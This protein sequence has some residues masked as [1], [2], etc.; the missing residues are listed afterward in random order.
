M[1]STA[2]SVQ[3]GIAAMRSGP[4]TM[5]L[6]RIYTMPGQHLRDVDMSACFRRCSISVNRQQKKLGAVQPE[7]EPLAKPRSPR[8]R[9]LLSQLETAKQKLE[10]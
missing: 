10:T 6:T 3:H 5:R 1:L 9:L 8:Q 4:Q 2:E 7:A